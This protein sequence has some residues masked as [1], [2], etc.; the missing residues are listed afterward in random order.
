MTAR[1]PSIPPAHTGRGNASRQPACPV[2]QP[3]R[4]GQE[5]QG[6]SA[7][8]VANSNLGENAIQSLVDTLNLPTGDAVDQSPNPE[9]VDGVE[10]ANGARNSAAGENVQGHVLA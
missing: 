4:P 8:L 6:V 1:R 7:A 5:R 3:R 2:A 10:R 9:V